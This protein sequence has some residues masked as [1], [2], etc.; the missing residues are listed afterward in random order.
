MLQGIADGNQGISGGGAIIGDELVLT[1]HV[2]SAPGNSRNGNI[3]NVRLN[4]TT[5]NGTFFSVG[6]AFDTVGSTFISTYTAGTMTVV[7]SP[8][9]L[10]ASSAPADLL[11]LD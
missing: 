1:L 2:S 5:L 10:T 11:L 8:V 4:R 6:T 9:P 7:G 3:I